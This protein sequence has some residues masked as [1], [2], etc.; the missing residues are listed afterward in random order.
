MFP[1]VSFPIPTS[2]SMK[3]D[4]LTIHT[5]PHHT[6]NIPLLP[7]LPRPNRFTQPS[8]PH[9]NPLS[10]SLTKPTYHFTRPDQKY[11]SQ[12]SLERS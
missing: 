1:V 12:L 5:A 10:L 3:I 6:Y 9:E 4:K 8:P 11:L 7:P 2:K